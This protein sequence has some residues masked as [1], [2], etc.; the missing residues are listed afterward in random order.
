[1]TIGS[2]RLYQ[3]FKYGVYAALTL[4]I[5]LFYAEESAAAALQY[6][7]G[8]DLENFREAFSATVDTFAWVLLLLMFELETHLLDERHFTPTVTVSL[9]AVRALGYAAI[10]MAFVGYIDDMVFVSNTV[11]LEGISSLCQLP[12]GEWSWPYTFGEYLL[13]TEANCATLSGADNF[14]RYP[15]LPLVID[16][17]GNT[18]IVRLAWADIINSAAWILIVVILEID[19]WLQEHHRY[20][21]VALHASNALKFVLYSTL[22]LVA[23]Y[24][25]FK[26]DLL[27]TWD[28]YMWLVAFVFIELNVLE[29][30]QEERATAA[31]ENA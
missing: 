28:A 22:L 10:V 24:W 27:D 8:I 6:P 21:G 14:L 11:P 7:Q 30:R 29:W 4:N 13:I 25:T 2:S 5:F 3:F 26:G 31:A 16:A 12:P 18:E 17:A 23:I 9:R 20:E 15:D 19:V 1:M